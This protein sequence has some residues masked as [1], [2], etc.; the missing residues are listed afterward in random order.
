MTPYSPMDPPADIDPKLAEYLKNELTR[1][2]NIAPDPRVVN[3][4]TTNVAPSKPR[5]GD[6]R[7]A[8]GAPGWNPGAGAGFYG[9]YG[10]AWV[11]LG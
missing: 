3:I 9:Y 7:L 8:S 2:A 6:V 4:E 10:G 5:A 1:I 11:K